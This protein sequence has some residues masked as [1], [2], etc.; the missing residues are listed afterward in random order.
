MAVKSLIGRSLIGNV[1]KGS[2]AQF[3][4]VS[5]FREKPDYETAKEFLAQG[6]FLWNAG[7]FIWSVETIVEAFKKYQPGQYELFG[8]G[9]SC[10]NTGEER[11]FIQENYA[12]AENISIDYAILEQ[13]NSIYTLPATFDWNDLGTWGALY[14]K[15]E[16]DDASNAVVNAQVLLEDAK[17]NMIRAPKGKVV[18]V[19]GLE[20]YIIVDK[21]EVL[22]IYPKEK[23]QDIKKVLTQVKEKFGD[24]FA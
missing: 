6:N 11:A 17:G 20:D 15:L 16:K 10:Y 18:V 3:K 8:G 14:D 23:Q 22:L 7:I 9:I 4:K 21:E 2:D 13:S 12:K 19:D 5:Q 1:E 24:Q